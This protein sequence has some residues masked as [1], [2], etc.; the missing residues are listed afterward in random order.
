[1][2]AEIL[3]KEQ[4]IREL[5]SKLADLSKE[6]LRNQTA[7]AQKKKEFEDM[8]SRLE[9]KEYALIQENEDLRRENEKLKKE[10]QVSLI[11]NCFKCIR[12]IMRAKLKEILRDNNMKL[13]SARSSALWRLPREKWRSLMSL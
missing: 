2:E 10:E 9:A 3:Q 1:M 7:L 12:S 13:K 8:R 4:A 6:N 5:E 11:N